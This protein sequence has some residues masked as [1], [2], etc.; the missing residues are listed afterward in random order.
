MRTP[1]YKIL[2]EIYHTTPDSKKGIIVDI[3]YHYNNDNLMYIISTGFDEEFTCYE[4]ELTTE[5]TF[6]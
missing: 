3:I 2:Q 5:K 1:K 4:R 6:Y